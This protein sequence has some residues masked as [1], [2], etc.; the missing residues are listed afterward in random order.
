MVRIN[1][2]AAS[3]I[4]PFKVVLFDAFDAYYYADIMDTMNVFDTF[5]NYELAVKVADALFVIKNYKWK[6]LQEMNDADGGWD[7]RVFNSEHA[8]VY[9][10]HRKY[11]KRW[12]IESG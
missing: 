7:V 6:S 3:Q 5:D 2:D 10:A 4:A 11:E 8:C 9:A 12:F 1:T